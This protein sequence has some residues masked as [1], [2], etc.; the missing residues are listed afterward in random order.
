MQSKMMAYD[1]AVSELNSARL[2][3]I[4]YPVVHSLVSA[5]LNGASDVSTNHLNTLLPAKIS[6]VTFR[7]NDAKFPCAV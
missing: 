5:S 4:S 6:S 2:R 7:A 1:R 3:G